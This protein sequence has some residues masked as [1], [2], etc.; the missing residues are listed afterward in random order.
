[1]KH[2]QFIFAAAAMLFISSFANAQSSNKSSALPTFR[3]GLSTQVG[4]LNGN[5]NSGYVLGGGL[6]TEAFLYRKS[7]VLSS[8]AQYSQYQQDGEQTIVTE[9]IHQQKTVTV[10]TSTAQS[11]VSVPI[12][13]KWRSPEVF[14]NSLKTYV[15][16]G[17][18]NNF[19]IKNDASYI[20]SSGVKERIANSDAD[21][22]NMLGTIG[23][24]TEYN[25]YGNGGIATMG[26]N[27]HP[28]LGNSSTTLQQW[29][30]QLGLFF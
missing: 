7:L 26:I 15:Q 5:N 17:I 11:Y 27:Y 19:L 9:G 23:V 24:G 18:V 6:M 25:I 1:M 4:A 8:G 3:F 13:L 21:S 14:S 29:S 20:A 10:N 22:Y 2:I 12:S 30:I 28:Q 16:G